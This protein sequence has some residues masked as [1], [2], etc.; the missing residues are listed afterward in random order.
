MWL[1]SLVLSYAHAAPPAQVWGP[2]CVVP[3][4]E[5][6]DKGEGTSTLRYLVHVEPHDGSGLTLTLERFELVALEGQPLKPEEQEL[7]QKMLGRLTTPPAFIGADGQLA[8][9]PADLR[10]LRELLDKLDIR[11]AE[12]RGMLKMFKSDELVGLMAADLARLWWAWSG[13]WV[14]E[15]PPAGGSI[16]GEAPY[17]GGDGVR[18]PV[19]AIWSREVDASG[20]DTL[21]AELAVP[22]SRLSMEWMLLMGSGAVGTLEVGP[23]RSVVAEAQL[24]PATG[25]PLH[26]RLEVVDRLTGGAAHSQYR[27]TRWLWDEAQGCAVGP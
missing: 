5:E 2:P 12:Q 16:T 15:I 24:D 8:G 1:V 22:P 25:R 26:T 6:V 23:G 9:V 21:R 10:T 27:D 4:L 7:A 3:V 11:R 18:G 13:A 19:P 14:G 20:A 17:L